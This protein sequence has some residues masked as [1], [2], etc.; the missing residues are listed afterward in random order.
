ML[1]TRP[2][3]FLAMQMWLQIHFKKESEKGKE[4]VSRGNNVRVGRS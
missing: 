4:A 1:R 2:N 3:T